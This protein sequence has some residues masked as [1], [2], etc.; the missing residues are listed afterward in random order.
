MLPNISPPHAGAK[1]LRPVA[2]DAAIKAAPP[3]TTEK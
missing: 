1:E 3:A 2:V